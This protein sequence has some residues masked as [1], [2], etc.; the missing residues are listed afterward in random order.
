MGGD[1]II[2]NNTVLT[3]IDGLRALTDIGGSLQIGGVGDDEGNPAL[4]VLVGAV[5]VGSAPSVP[6]FQALSDLGGLA[7]YRE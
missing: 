1:V 6:A 4:E 5:G 7:Y 2:Q 3:R